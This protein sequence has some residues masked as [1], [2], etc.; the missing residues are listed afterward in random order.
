MNHQAPAQLFQMHQLGLTYRAKPAL[1]AIDW[2]WHATEH[3]AVLGANG[4]GKT[5]V[6]KVL[7]GELPHFSGRLDRSH[8]LANR[9]AILVDF[10]QGRL[11]C[12]RD[13]KLDCSEFAASASDSGTR[14]EDLLPESE[15]NEVLRRQVL[16]LLQL[17]PLLDR[18]VRFLSTGELR[19]TL[20]ANALLLEPPLLILDSPMDG[21]D[22]DT[23]RSL[24]E[25]LD[26]LIPQLPAVLVLCR[27][28]QEIPKAIDQVLVL[29]RGRIAACGPKAETLSKPATVAALQAPNL[30][31]RISA[32]LIE[33]ANASSGEIPD[34]VTIELIDV[35]AS[36]DS[37]PVFTS[38][39]WKLRRNQHCM[40]AGPNGSGKSTLLDLLT[41]D[42]HKAY[43]QHV[44]LFGHLRG[45]GESVW[46]VKN[47]FGRVDARLQFSVPNGSDVMSVVAS[48][49][50]DSV[51]LHR[52]PSDLQ[53]RISKRWLVCLGLGRYAAADFFT[54]SFGLQRLVLLARAMVKGPDILLLDEATLGLDSAHRR[55]LL[56]AVDEVI[57]AGRTQLLFVSHTIGERPSC[58]NQL[59]EFHPTPAGSHVSVTDRV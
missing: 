46:D 41:G 1:R 57:S 3:W 51:G 10:E 40:I 30:D 55:L 31:F 4:S 9:G 20:L 17:G 52:K 14:V 36:F 16:D 59:L 49:F 58:I 50:F 33:A 38:L 6:A 47:R 45:R 5:T 53:H 8:D 13:R 22:R 28:Q 24:S 11:L 39:N 37:K 42:N 12:D 56:Q 19:K 21:L 26:T 54:L 44:A 15:T 48:G 32:D 23:Q 2:C 35:S 27:D 7:S 29:D 43:G 25:A 34:A 18:G